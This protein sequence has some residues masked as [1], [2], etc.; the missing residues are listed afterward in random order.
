MF[1]LIPGRCCWQ[2][3]TPSYFNTSHVSIN[4]S[5][6]RSPSAS[7]CISIHLMFL[8]ISTSTTTRRSG[9]DFNTSHVS[10]NLDFLA[11]WPE[12][13]AYFNTS[14]VSINLR[15][16]INFMAFKN[17]FNTSHV[18]INPGSLWK[19]SPIQRISIH[20]MFLLIPWLCTAYGPSFSISI[21][22][23]FLL[24]KDGK[25]IAV[26]IAKFQYISCFY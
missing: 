22:L 5:D 2:H 8:L 15:A 1:L 17:D 9:S 4:R 7:A 21:H 18:S 14:H 19:R 10:I 16:R 13:F 11:F 3:T 25:E 26:T 6:P 24:I 12:S 23:M 20:L